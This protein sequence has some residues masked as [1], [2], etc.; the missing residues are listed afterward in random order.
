MWL[1]RTPTGAQ[2]C[3]WEVVARAALYAMEAGRQHMHARMGDL[4]TLTL[5]ASR[6]AVACMWARVQ[7]LLHLGVPRTGWEEVGTG[8]LCQSLW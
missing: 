1:A 2:Q 8:R 5:Q 6:W 7:V 3:V 4:R